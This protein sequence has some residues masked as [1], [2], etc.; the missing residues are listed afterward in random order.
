MNAV[1]SPLTQLPRELF[2]D[3]LFYNNAIEIG[4]LWMSGNKLLRSRMAMPSSVREFH[5]DYSFQKYYPPHFLSCLSGLQS[6]SYQSK[7]SMASAFRSSIIMAIPP[8]IT[9]LSSSSNVNAASLLC[10]L[11][12]NMSQL[13]PNLRHLHSDESFLLTSY[14]SPIIQV[15]PPT[16]TVLELTNTTLWYPDVANLP[17]SLQIL[18]L[19]SL[20]SESASESAVFE[21]P[22]A[23]RSLKL[24]EPHHR[25]SQEVG[26]DHL[27]SMVIRS[28]SSSLPHLTCLHFRTYLNAAEI[29]QLPSTI[30]DLHI[31]SDPICLI[32]LSKAMPKLRRLTTGQLGSNAP[33]V[34]SNLYG[35]LSSALPST[36]PLEHLEMK[37]SMELKSELGHI[38]YPQNMDEATMFGSGSSR[39]SFVLPSTLTSVFLPEMALKRKQELMALPSGLL[40]LAVG[41]LAPTC[42]ALL[43]TRL[44]RLEWDFPDPESLFDVTSTS[45]L[46]S[47]ITHILAPSIAFSSLNGFGRLRRLEKFEL[48]LVHERQEGTCW[49]ANS[50]EINLLPTSITH[51]SLNLQNTNSEKADWLPTIANHFPGLT[52]L[53]LCFNKGYQFPSTAI[54]NLPKNLK[55]LALNPCVGL[56]D[57]DFMKWNFPCLENLSIVGSHCNVSNDSVESW[58][59][60]LTMLHIPSSDSEVDGICK[61]HLPLCLDDLKIGDQEPSFFFE[62]RNGW[63]DICEPDLD[64]DAEDA[65]Y[66]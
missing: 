61:I 65:Y 55:S 26:Q 4:F 54:Q 66:A 6:L 45:S 53:A 9:K 22:P 44:L 23:L 52:S 48:R 33:G 34:V 12:S 8:S 37:R 62:K 46:P 20:S 49:T 41:S 3:I 18:H 10:Q 60:K 32:E 2:S 14:V 17:K 15:L 21:F 59:R 38:G 63:D 39:I 50:H 43:P 24:K 28:L 58:P 19:A 25:Y 42:A 27:V 31:E 35:F 36:M 5:L 29:A 56:C 11:S 47:S 7:V 64:Y 30:V 1:F 57:G 40:F 51:L 16:L 13:L